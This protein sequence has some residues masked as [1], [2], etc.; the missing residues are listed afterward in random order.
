MEIYIYI[1]LA[2]LALL[3]LICW[4]VG[5]FN[6]LILLALLL[7]KTIILFI[8]FTKRQIIAFMVLN[9]LN[10][11]AFFGYYMLQFYKIVDVNC[12]D[13]PFCLIIKDKQGNM[14]FER[15]HR[16]HL[17]GIWAQHTWT[18]NAVSKFI[19]TAA[20][21]V[22][23]G[24]GDTATKIR[25][26][27]EAYDIDITNLERCNNTENMEECIAKFNDLN[28]FFTRK[29]V[30]DE[31]YHPDF[32]SFGDKHNY[33]LSPCDCRCMYFENMNTAKNIWIKGNKVDNVNT[34]LG[35]NKKSV[36]KSKA[37]QQL[38]RVMDGNLTEYFRDGKIISCR[39]AP[40][41][42]HRIHAPVHG[43]FVSQ[44]KI[45]K[46]Y[47]SVH[48][49]VIDTQNVFFKN[50]RKCYYIKTSF[51]IVAMCIIGATC[52]GSIVL[53]NKT[54]ISMGDE[55][56]Y[57]QF[58]GSTVVMILPPGNYEIDPIVQDYSTER[59]E[60]YLKVGEY[61]GHNNTT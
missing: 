41:D 24:R 4:S 23:Q 38:V 26:F 5:I 25:N 53:H 12:N 44:Y 29:K 6:I 15:Y 51:G 22:C 37:I 7:L 14:H 11:A 42:Y 45:G 3:D 55:I 34:L 19:T 59:M 31:L 13:D 61:L 28:D 10:N 47:K 40:Q 30:K 46:T 36:K 58:G 48:P 50:V 32:Y 54:Q 9:L 43:T 20:K 35:F 33:I 21:Q 8:D 57:F 39:L 1:L 49:K 52:V 60:T 2:F 56:G 18:V 16:K 27:I 17:F